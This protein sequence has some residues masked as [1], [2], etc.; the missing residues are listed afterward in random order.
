DPAFVG[1]ARRIVLGKHSGTA[2]VLHALSALGL[3][4]DERQA[5]LVLEQVRHRA[6]ALKGVIDAQELLKLYASAQA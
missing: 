1:R 4:A 5:R 3:S 6:A 2:G